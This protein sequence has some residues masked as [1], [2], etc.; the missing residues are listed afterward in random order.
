[1]VDRIYVLRFV[2]MDLRDLDG[3]DMNGTRIIRRLGWDL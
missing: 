2:F 3:M 1:M